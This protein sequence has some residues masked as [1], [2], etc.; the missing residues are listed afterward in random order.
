MKKIKKILGLICVMLMM[1]SMNVFANT[2]QDSVIEE[3]DRPTQLFKEHCD[4]FFTNPQKYR[5]I[6]L[7]GND[8]TKS[9]YDT[10]IAEYINH[11]Y[12]AIWECFPNE[13][14]AFSW[15]EDM[16]DEVQPYSATTLTKTASKE[17]YGIL[18]TK[19]HMA[20]KAVEFSYSIKGKYK[21]HIH[22]KKIASASNPTVSVKFSE[23]GD[24][25][26]ATYSNVSGSYSI[27][28]T[29]TKVTFKGSFKVKLAFL[30]GNAWTE[31]LG[32]VTN[33]VKGSV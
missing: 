30:G 33:S 10:H 2:N 17:F 9:F 8:I 21:V 32:T 31:T 20:G 1:F 19:K 6:D 13:I 4:N 12:N 7:N 26:S 25:F 18:K 3:V 16:V 23:V 27:N 29:N 14:A 22:A 24:W 28:S 11:D 15:E 5:A